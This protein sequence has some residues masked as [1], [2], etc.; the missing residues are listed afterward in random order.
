MLA[1]FVVIAI[2]L[3]NKIVYPIEMVSDGLK[4]I[5]QGE[6]NLSKRLQV[7]GNDEIKPILYGDDDIHPN[8]IMQ[9]T[10]CQNCYFLA[11]MSALAEKPQYIKSILVIDNASLYLIMYIFRNIIHLLE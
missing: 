6:G 7:I 3:A 8:N 10:G 11:A 4:E 5:A 2:V 9:G 1:L